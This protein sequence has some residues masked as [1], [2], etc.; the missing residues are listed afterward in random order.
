MYVSVCVYIY[1]NIYGCW[2]FEIIMIG[3]E[4]LNVHRPLPFSL[5]LSPSLTHSLTHSFAHS[6]AHSPPFRTRSCCCV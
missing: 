5:S 4:Q 1:V 3:E 6:F 2:R